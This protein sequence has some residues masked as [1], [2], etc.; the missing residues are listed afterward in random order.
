[1]SLS[2]GDNWAEPGATVIMRNSLF[3]SN[4]ADLDSGGVV[5]ADEY[6]TMVVEGDGN[7]FEGNECYGDGGVIVATTDTSITIEGGLF[8]NNRV[9]EVSLGSCG[10]RYILKCSDELFI[11]VTT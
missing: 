4:W 6:C 2:S 8:I 7:V 5:S 9:E 3:G 10:F 11:G 1:M